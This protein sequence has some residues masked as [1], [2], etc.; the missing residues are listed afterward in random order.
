MRPEPAAAA[1]G[2]GSARRP[3]RPERAGRER[4]ADDGLPRWE[5]PLLDATTVTVGDRSHT[6]P[7]IARGFGR[8]VLVRHARGQAGVAGQ[9][10]EGERY[11][12]DG[13]WHWR[14]RWVARGAG[15][16]WGLPR[17]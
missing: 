14:D 5:R 9:E 10:A 4:P 8:P 2:P 17:E 12:A 3:Y 15:G 7:Q 11:E 16:A 1:R 6:G 13:Q